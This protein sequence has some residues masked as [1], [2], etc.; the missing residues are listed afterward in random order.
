MNE[1]KKFEEDFKKSVPTEWF[2]YRFRD[3][4][5]SFNKGE[6]SNIRFQA[7]NICDCLIYTGKE[8]NLIELKSH[9]GKSLPL[10]CIRE[11]QLNGLLDAQEKR[12]LCYLIVNFRDTEE[13]Y[14][15]RITDIKLFIDSTSRK[16]IPLDYF[17]KHGIRI[18]QTK[19]IIRYRYKLE[20]IFK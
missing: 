10:A 14:L 17:R 13:T 11:N 8:L 6:S 3:G 18:K 15:M 9:K 19:K 7:K 20:E 1:G 4:T 5:A 16:S 2:Y 12:C